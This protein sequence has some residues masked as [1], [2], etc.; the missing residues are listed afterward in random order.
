ML[1]WKI[2]KTQNLKTPKFKVC[3]PTKQG[4]F[5]VKHYAAK[6]LWNLN[7]LILNYPDPQTW[8]CIKFNSTYQSSS[9]GLPGGNAL[10]LG[11]CWWLAQL[12]ISNGNL[13]G[14]NDWS[15]NGWGGKV[16]NQQS[17]VNINWFGYNQSRMHQPKVKEPLSL[18]IWKLRLWDRIEN[19]LCVFKAL[20]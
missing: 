11:V 5:K 7:I 19:R 2:F 1:I 20:K 15:L 9:I 16:S 10:S 13:R 14:I 18:F 17:P 3:S 6:G 8:S 4:N 12:D